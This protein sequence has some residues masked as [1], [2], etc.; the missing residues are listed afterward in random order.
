MG[1]STCMTEKN[2]ECCEAC[3]ERE[4]LGECGDEFCPCHTKTDTWE[5]EFETLPHPRSSHSK[6]RRRKLLDLGTPSV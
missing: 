3:W 2:R 1:Y 6:T 4:N 5:E